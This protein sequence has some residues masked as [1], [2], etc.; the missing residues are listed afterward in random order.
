MT[1]PHEL[2]PRVVV[3]A[4]LWPIETLCGLSDPALAD[5]ARG[6]VTDEAFAGL[7]AEAMR[8]QQRRLA[9]ATIDDPGFAAALALANPT[10]YRRLAARPMTPDRDKRSRQTE[11]TLYRY[12]A[13]AVWRTTPYGLWAG[14]ALAAWGTHTAIVPVPGRRCV[15]PDLAAFAAL[16][17]ALTSRPA[18]AM[19]GRFKLNPTLRRG[20]TPQPHWYFQQ[21]NVWRA[22]RGT[23]AL[24]AA[25]AA[26]ADGRPRRF[27]ECARLAGAA[28][29]RGLLDA[30]LLVGGVTFP[31]RFATVWEALKRAGDQL[32]E[33]ERG[34]WRRMVAETRRICRAVDGDASAPTIL[35]AQERLLDG[36]RGMARQFGVPEPAAA[37]L[38]C[39][40]ALPFRVTLGTDWRRRL[41]DA[42]AD[43]E[44]FEA[45]Q[46]V[47]AM[48]ARLYAR[49]RL[50]GGEA[51][52]PSPG[53]DWR[54]LLAAAGAD[55][56]ALAR[57]EHL[58][59]ALGGDGRLDAPPAASFVSSAAAGTLML[60]LGAGEAAI[61]GSSAE[62]ALAFGRFT[63]LFGTTGGWRALVAWAA[64]TV[65]ETAQARGAQACELV[66]PKGTVHNTL[67]R[68]QLGRL[69]VLDYWGVEPDQL[70]CRHLVPTPDTAD[71]QMVVATEDGSRLVVS[72]FSVLD[73]G[74]GDPASEAL[75]FS[76]GRVH[77]PGLAEELVPFPSE[78]TG[79]RVSPALRLSGGTAV[80]PSRLHLR[81]EELTALLVG[82]AASR[83]RAWQRLA[84]RHHLPEL[85]VLTPAEDAPILIHRD[86]PLAFDAALKG[87]GPDLPLLVLTLPADGFLLTDAKGRR[88][89]T[90]IGLPWRA[91]AG[92]APAGL[93]AVQRRAGGGG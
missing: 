12:L 84:A 57:I 66:P 44:R 9:T 78:R 3:R 35:T 92:V 37:G 88:Y 91:A 61:A 62:P 7:H 8:R 69:P 13:R 6:A 73:L 5:A 29:C 82:S 10:A 23:P 87:C 51:Q 90:E 4:A 42:L 65:T 36:L 72:L 20:G 47:T 18:Y 31:R 58:E 41:T 79:G 14:T 89:A 53:A 38:R 25:I 39:D 67:A 83:F 93:A 43:A 75:L 33:P 70:P 32:A 64:R 17:A 54:D 34:A 22:A 71:G 74:G 52:P 86:S 15:T 77:V 55:H 49:R 28:C 1:A 40:A 11:R 85:V 50:E 68:P 21:G 16:F 59:H 2:A 80:R 26:L 19:R 48:A 27:A 56:D 24:D 60:R 63:G 76:S 30:G 45:G 81:G 46:S